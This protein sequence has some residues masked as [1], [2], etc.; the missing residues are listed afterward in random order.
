MHLQAVAA[1]GAAG[2]LLALKGLLP[3]VAR[4]LVHPQLRAGQE[5]LGALGALW[6]GG[7]SAHGHHP[8]SESGR[9]LLSCH[10]IIIINTLR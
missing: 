1:G 7:A 9:A 10:Q 4:R 2:A 8:G 3:A 5:A 6:R